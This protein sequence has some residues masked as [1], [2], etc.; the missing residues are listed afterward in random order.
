MKV[1]TL[2]LNPAFDIHYKIENFK[3]YTENYIAD[4]L[5]QSGG[6]GVNI[7]RALNIAR[8]ENTAYIVVGE[9][10][11]EEFLSGI[12]LNAK[13]FYEAVNIRRNITI[14]SD[15]QPE[16]RFSM[17]NFALSD[18]VFAQVSKCLL[19]ECDKNTILTFTGRIPKGI[20]KEKI[21]NLL[22]K[23]KE[24]GVKTVIDSNSL[25]K[26]EIF[27]IK[28]WLIKPN[29]YEFESIFG[30]DIS[31]VHQLCEMG[32]ENVIVSLEEKGVVFS[33]GK[34]TISVVPPTVNV[35]SS[36]GAGDSLI[37]G[38]IYGFV[39][40]RSVTDTVKYAVAF[41]T[42]ACLTD[43]TSPPIFKDINN[44]FERTK[45]KGDL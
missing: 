6:K 16:T 1:I 21:V 8:V 11:K 2:T 43:G 29:S 22:I 28:P 38:F 13:Y 19:T 20:E 5:A 32:I 4:I 39:N 14:H 40:G 42:S 37:A 17:D 31:K 9:K 44:I 34:G 18:K 25:T 27:L 30:G 3:P 36:I 23:L 45:V 12:D 7:S 33:N 26:D 41:G 15:N 10:D 35:V 24:Q